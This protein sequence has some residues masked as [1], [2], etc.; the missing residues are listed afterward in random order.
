MVDVILASDNVT[1]LGGPSKLD[2][3]LSI[4]APGTRGSLF[5]VGVSNPNTLNPDVDF[6]VLPNIFDVFINSNG[7]SEDY[8]QAY[9]YTS[10]EGGASWTPIFNINQSVYS[11][12][13]VLDF[14]DGQSSINVDISRMALDT[15]PFEA[16]ENSFA[17]FNVQATVSNIDLEDLAATNNPISF[18]LTVGDAYFDNEGS[19]D[20]G[21]VPLFLPLVFSAAEFDGTN[22]SP[23]TNKKTPAYLTISFA[24]PDKIL[25]IITAG[26]GV[27]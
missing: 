22:W 21:V 9:Q 10:Q 23:V 20:P 13:E 3:D 26:G 18:A 12:T 5:F 25:E 7:A 24:N 14:L 1:V 11:T 17:Y 27:S 8:L 4:G 16:F 2:V 19:F 6:P 15:L